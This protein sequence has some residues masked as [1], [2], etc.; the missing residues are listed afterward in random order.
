MTVRS[1][2]SLLR[3]LGPRGLADVLRERAWSE[4][5]AFGLVCDLTDIPPVRAPKIEVSME[6]RDPREF[7]GFLEELERVT[8]DDYVEVD[9]RTRFCDAGMAG[10]HVAEDP[11]GRP[12]YA[13]WLIDSD[14]QD[15][16]HRATHG[17]FPHLGPDE[18]L[19]EGAYTFVGYRS[20]GALAEGARQL[21]VNAAEKG[22]TRCYTYVSM[23]NTPAL[24]GVNHAGFDVDHVRVTTFRAGRRRIEMRPPQPEEWA[25]WEAATAPRAAATAAA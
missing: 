24:R 5:R 14:N 11:Q 3:Q 7:R 18:A 19:V 21:L 6:P 12:I 10:L 2:L 16:L 9:T 8:G 25:V 13:Q 4:H 1:T 22:A 20:L 15:G 23:G 17:Q